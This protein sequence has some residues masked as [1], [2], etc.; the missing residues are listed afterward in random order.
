MREA[1]L[2]C[3]RIRNDKLEFNTLLLLQ[4][5]VGARDRELRAVGAMR[6]PCD[7]YNALERH[8]L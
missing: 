2:Y 6:F 5:C 3:I 7:P 4:K 1:R 8:C